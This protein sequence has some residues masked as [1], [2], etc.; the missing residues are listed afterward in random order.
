MYTIYLEYTAVL[1]TYFRWLTSI[2]KQG[3][4]VPSSSI[5]IYVTAKVWSGP[6]MVSS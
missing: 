4:E 1:K 6:R 5:N 3:L 2:R